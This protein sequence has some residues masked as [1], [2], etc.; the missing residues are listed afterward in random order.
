MAGLTVLLSP[1]SYYAWWVLLI[2][3][4][5]LGYAAVHLGFWHSVGLHAAMNVAALCLC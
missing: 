2:Q 1:M 4:L 3:G 5:I